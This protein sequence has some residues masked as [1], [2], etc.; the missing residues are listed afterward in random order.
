VGKT[1]PKR[2]THC[3][4]GHEF[5]PQNT[6]INK[7][8][9]RSCKLCAALRVR[10]RYMPKLRKNNKRRR[11]NPELRQ[12][13]LSR[14]KLTNQKRRL[15]TYGLTE[16]DFQS[17]VKLQNNC[18][19]ICKSPFDMENTLK[20][21]HVD[22][23]HK[24]NVVRGL[25]CAR[26][27]LGLGQFKDNVEILRTASD[28][29]EGKRVLITGILGQDGYYLSHFLTKKGYQI[30]GLVRRTSQPNQNEKDL[31]Q[32]VQLFEGDLTDFSSVHRI[33]SE[34]RPHEIYNLAAQ[35][36]VG[37]SFKEP[38]HTTQ[39]NLFGVLNL[40]ESIRQSNFKPRLYQAS[41]SEMFGGIY[42]DDLCNENT[43]FYPKSPYGVAKLAA[44]Y[45][46]INY[47]ESYGIHA[48]NGILFN[49]E[50]SKRGANFVTRK[51]TLAIA[52]IKAGK[53]DK[54]FLGNLEAKRDWGYAGDF[55]EA[56]YLILNNKLPED[57]VVSTGET[58]SV[59]EFCEIA[60]E[61][62]GLGDYQKYVEVDPRFYRPAEVHVLIGDYSK[63]QKELGWEPKTKFVELV[64]RM[65]SH[66]LK[67]VI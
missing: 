49:H 66:D 60:F 13:D 55:V 67:G 36:N 38:L 51:I 42:G 31:P 22:H 52:A 35:S 47:R 2:K 45:A 11:E 17:L 15:E 58:H 1:G 10:E 41:T 24:T 30:F 34:V 12:H 5:T 7:L 4:R 3:G 48:C 9:Y 33:I 39:V 43:A 50:S 19:A 23:C 37:V 18:C 20:T 27:N 57:F 14:M 44:H 40:L 54:L 46:V 21:C 6:I 28:Y 53:Q 26:C 25:L 59:R 64:H 16:Q 8:G 56:M 62:A 61:Y 65:V 63:I 29:L 32:G